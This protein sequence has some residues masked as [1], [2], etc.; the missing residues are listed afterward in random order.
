M[1]GQD[2]VSLLREEELACKVDTHSLNL[3]DLVSQN[4]GV[5]NDTITDDVHRAI[6]EDTRRNGVQ[7][8]TFASEVD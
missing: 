6:T 8:E 1:S 5:N 2:Q 7:Y 3:C 4:Y